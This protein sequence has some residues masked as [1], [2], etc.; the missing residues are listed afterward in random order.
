MSQKRAEPLMLFVKACR[1]GGLVR[2]C[3][4]KPFARLLHTSSSMAKSKF[5]YVRNFETDDTCLRNCYIVVRLDGRNFH[6]FAEQHKFAKPNDNRA[7]G[8]MTQ[9]ARSVMG[10][11]EDIVVAYGQSD[12]FSFV[13]KRTST[14]FKRRA[15]KLMTHVTSQFSSSY[16]FYWKDFFGEQP[17]LYPPGFDGRVV[18]YPSNRNLRDYL[19]WRQADCHINNL[20]NT[21]FWTLVQK[22]QLTTAQA[23]DRLKGTLA[24]DKN[25]ILFSEFNINYNNESALH[26]KGTTLIWEKQDETVVKRTKL[27][28]EEEKEVSV[29][30]SRRR[31]Q[32][33]YS[34]Q[35]FV[36]MRPPPPALHRGGV[37]SPRCLWLLLLLRCVAEAALSEG[38]DEQGSLRSILPHVK[39]YEITHP[40][41]LHPHRH[42]RSG[43][44][45]H[46]TEALVQ[47]S[48][49]GQELRLHLEKNEQLLA[50]GYQEV[51][52][53]PDGA[54]KSSSPVSTGH[55]F[56]HGEVLGM[57][58]SSVAVSTCSGLRGLISLNASVSYLIEPL[59]ASADAQRHAVFRAEHLH[60]PG[61]SCLHHHG[62]KEHGERLDDFIHGMMSP[63]SV[64][65]KRDLSQNM[66]YVELLLVAD[67]AEYE[68]H[69]RSLER[70]KTKLLEAANLVDKYYKAL[71]IRV[72]LI[73][74][75]VWT[76]QDKISVSDNPHS[77]LAAFLSWR[78]KQLRALPNDNAQ[79]ITGRAFQGTTIGLA[80]LKAMC[81]DYQSGGVNTDH[82]E[83][84]VGVAATMAHEMGHNFGMNHDSTGCC[85][86]RPED[87]GCIMAAATGHPFPR[88][89]NEC[90]LKELKSYLS[91]GGGKCLFNLPNTRVMYGGQRC[92]N[93][94]LEDGEE[95]DC[96]NEEECT[97][98]CCNANNCTLK[99]GAECAH[100]VCCDNCKLKSPGVL[101]RAPSGSCDLPEYCD[102]KAESCPANFYL[103]DGTSCAGGKAY[104]YTGMCLTLEQQCR[105]LWGQ[106]GRQAPDLCFQKVN[107]AGDMYGNCGKDLLGKYRSCKDR[108]ALCGKIQCLTSASKPIENNAVLIETTVRLGNKKIQC[109]GT[110]VYKAGQVDEETQGDT[111]DPGLVMT[112]TKCGDDSICFNGE[113]R[114][115]SFLRADECN[116][117]CNGHGLCNNNHNC[118]CDAGWAPPL[119]NQRG[120]GGS[121]DSGPVISYSN[122]L[123]V[124]LVLPLV[125]FVVLAAVGLWCRY[126]HKLRPLK[127][128]APPPVPNCS[129]PVAGKSLHPDSQVNGHANPTFLLK[130]QNSD[131]LGKS[132]PRPSPS[133]PTRG[134]AIT[135]PAVKPPPIPAYATGQKEPPPQIHPVAAAQRQYSPQAYTPPSLKSAQL[136]KQ[137]RNQAPPP[138]SG[139][140]P[141][142]SVDAKTRSQ[143]STAPKPIPAPP[144]RPPPP[145]PVSKPSVEQ[146]QTRG[147]QLTTN[148]LQRG[149][150]AL[151]PS[152][153][154]K[155]PNSTQPPIRPIKL[156]L[157]E[158]CN[159]DDV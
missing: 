89:F 53:T 101:C 158:D 125:L 116:A 1:F 157:S 92:G 71:S 76:D 111:L 58:D 78:R 6:K 14:L 48:A 126:R 75:E 42:R 12:E 87:G 123:P 96:G 43:N 149:K 30:R 11:L 93:G 135:R 102:G 64:R 132:S 144:S 106:D 10:E 69:E 90:N 50:P 146:Q 121:I 156:L 100:G 79:L 8:L 150:A 44:K 119:C 55:C 59:P 17:L 36:R 66:K 122:L 112:G 40:I 104:C 82:S 45:E 114:N 140:P 38:E 151:A 129:V 117:K 131:H 54:R 20:Y 24:A 153:G 3:A 113:C 108:D 141:L 4:I 29:T 105:S 159:D 94:Y 143:H 62:N 107:E 39:S 26:K 57:E 70:T 5:E 142:P 27:P 154:Q 33:Y 86:A 139:P 118:H 91:S 7:L 2:S 60:L 84:A 61:G 115:A 72:A 136:T 52:Y 98:P 63:Q 124:L 37:R 18:L 110:H 13:F 77:T 83:P 73:G 19:S 51:W 88:V 103:V 47:I 81:S 68:N 21:V 128:T 46:P 49:E 74:L 22:G 137:T 155:K 35:L 31:V 67:K 130:N 127:T 9:S 134:N 145:C 28:N 80:P 16:V 23:E 25:E 56:Y 95:C 34:E 152:A 148:A 41:W 15:S 138:P 97:S 99:A 32:A 109:M 85:Q 120:S 65:E 133:C 147:L